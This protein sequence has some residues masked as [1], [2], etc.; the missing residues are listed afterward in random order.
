LTGEA[1]AGTI[2]AEVTDA[3]VA[4]TLGYTSRIL[5]GPSADAILLGLIALLPR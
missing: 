2:F 1:H 5:T 3:V 4:P